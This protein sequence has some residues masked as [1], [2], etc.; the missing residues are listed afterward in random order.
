LIESET[1]ATADNAV[2]FRFPTATMNHQQA[3]QQQQQQQQQQYTEQEMQHA[4][5]F[6]EAVGTRDAL[7]HRLRLRAYAAQA[8]N[9][10]PALMHEAVSLKYNYFV[11]IVI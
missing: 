10:Q 3:P 6:A 9:A 4:A 8:A 1:T 11:A 7:L 2:F 5:A